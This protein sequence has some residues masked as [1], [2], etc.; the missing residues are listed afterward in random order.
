[1]DI[2]RKYISKEYLFLILNAKN[3]EFVIFLFYINSN[4]KYC[5]DTSGLSSLISKKLCV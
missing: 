3:M 1:M 5:R 4:L 2:H